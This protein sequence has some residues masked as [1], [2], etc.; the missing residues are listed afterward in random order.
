MPRLGFP[1][2]L[3]C[4][5]LPD[6]VRPAPAAVQQKKPNILFIFADDQC[7]DTIRS[8]GNDEIP[9]TQSRPTGRPPH[10]VHARLQHG[11]VERYRL[12]CQPHDAD[13]RQVPV[14][15]RRT[16]RADEA[17]LSGHRPAVAQLMAQ[18][19]YDTYFTG[20]WHIR[21]DATKT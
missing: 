16:L 7:F 6:A 12:R 4:L 9:D 20:K 2:L 17:A 15:P 8:L 19:G 1:I 3:T 21:A 18:A 14:A 11:L 10:D 5:F 13:H